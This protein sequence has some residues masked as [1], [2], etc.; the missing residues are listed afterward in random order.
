MK[1]PHHK[2]NSYNEDKRG[3]HV[4]HDKHESREEEQKRK[5]KKC[6]REL[7]VG[8]RQTKLLRS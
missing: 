4:L 7:R 3:E 6:L 8:Q 5:T 1:L 2:Q